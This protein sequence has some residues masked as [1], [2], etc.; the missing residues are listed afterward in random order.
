MGAAACTDFRKAIKRGSKM[1]PKNGTSFGLLLKF[2]WLFSNSKTL[3]NV[4]VVN[5]FVHAASL[6]GYLCWSKK[7][8][9]Q[10]MFFPIFDITVFALVILFKMP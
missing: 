2:F 6:K 10:G 4:N 7:G 3:K 5:V 9:Q 8:T 1:G